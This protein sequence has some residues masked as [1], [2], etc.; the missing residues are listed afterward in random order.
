[1]KIL[2]LSDLH[3]DVDNQKTIDLV[4]SQI[5][6]I[7]SSTD[8]ANNLSHVFISGDLTE[9]GDEDS[10]KVVHGLLGELQALDDNLQLVVAKGNHDGGRYRDKAV[11]IEQDDTNI[12][13]ID[14]GRDHVGHIT[15]NDFSNISKALRL[16]NDSCTG[17]TIKPLML[18]MHHPPTTLQLKK[19]TE[20]QGLSKESTNRLIRMV[21][22]YPNAM[23][24]I[25]AGHIH[26][27]S[28]IDYTTNDTLYT[29]VAPSLQFYCEKSGHQK[30]NGIHVQGFGL[31]EL[32]KIRE[33]DDN[34][35]DIFKMESASYTFTPLIHDDI[36][37]LTIFKNLDISHCIEEN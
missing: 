27:K 1:M 36:D 23:V 22:G 34:N 35:A 31:I 18:V 5:D 25:F 6:F 14:T 32:N 11:F 12:L 20:L 3:I 15:Q 21:A 7:K 29:I 19:K 16:T 37:E 10:H 4:K 17:T 9:R 26:P 28:I 24:I 2:H 33:T 13:M 30:L 8:I